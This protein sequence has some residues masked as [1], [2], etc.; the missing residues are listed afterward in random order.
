MVKGLYTAY[1]GMLNEQRRMDALAN[2]LA[3]V[4][5]TGFKKEGATSQAFD[6]ILAYN[7]KD[8]SEFFLTQREGSMVPGVKLGETYVDW[9]EGPFKETHSDLDLAIAGNGF[10][11]IE[12]TSKDGETST[13]YTRDGSFTLTQEGDLVTKDGD[14]VLD[15]MGNHIRLNPV[16]DVRINRAGEIYQNDAQVGTVG[17][18]DFEDYNYLEHYGENMWQT[19]EGANEVPAAAQVISGY[20]EQS[21]VNIVY[22]MTNMIAIQRNYESNQRVITTIDSTLQTA[23]NNLGRLT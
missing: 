2:S 23:V 20:L 18:T 16:Q 4:N 10:F 12:F 15:T 13:K 5:T 19:V 21:N 6:D 14:F 17:I 22:E 8:K 9:S 11:A 3:N 1:T 7:I